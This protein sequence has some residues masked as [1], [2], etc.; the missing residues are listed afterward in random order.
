MSEASK[1][2]RDDT[3]E[4]AI[5]GIDKTCEEYLE[6][7]I[8]QEDWQMLVDGLNKQADE[9][10]E[11]MRKQESFLFDVL[12][13]EKRLKE[14]LREKDKKVETLKD[15]LA[16][17]YTLDKRLVL[18]DMLELGDESEKNL[19]DEAHSTIECLTLEKKKLEDEKKH[20]KEQIDSIYKEVAKLS[21]TVVYQAT[22][23][24]MEG[25]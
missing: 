6:N 1:E 10:R 25:K 4:E 2:L 8:P 20:M 3:V 17:L 11:E 7:N 18:G 15:E 22:R 19:L 13:A 14:E 21:K 12:A 5:K 24:A 23:L 9:L 16:G